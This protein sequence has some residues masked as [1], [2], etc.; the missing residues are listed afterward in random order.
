[1][2]KIIMLLP[3]MFMS[4]SSLHCEIIFLICLSQ[5]LSQ[6][7][8]AGLPPHLPMRRTGLGALEVSQEDE[9]CLGTRSIKLWVVMSMRMLIIEA[10]IFR[11][12]FLSVPVLRTLDIISLGSHNDPMKHVILS[13]N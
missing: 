4:Y 8:R 11:C 7:F 6:L 9:T 3:Y 13:V 12:L 2:K 10:T 5:W 1:M